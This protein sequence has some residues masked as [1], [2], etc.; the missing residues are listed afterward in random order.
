MNRSAR[1]NNDFQN[2]MT[3]QFYWD[4]KIEVRLGQVDFYTKKYL[5]RLAGER[6]R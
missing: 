1:W 6:R 4:V 5:R 2:K 3:R